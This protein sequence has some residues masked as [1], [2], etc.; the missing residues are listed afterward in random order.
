MKKVAKNAAAGSSGRSARRPKKNTRRTVATGFGKVFLTL[1]LIC[2]ITGSL[3]VGAVA[4]YVIGFVKPYD[5]DLS[6]AKLKFTSIVYATDPS[7]KTPVQID[8]LSGD[9][10]RIWVNLSDVPDNLRNAFI[11]TEDQRFNEHEGVD[12]KRTV[13]AFANMVL[14]FNPSAGGGST[15]TQQLIKNLENNNFNRTIPVKIREIVTALDMEQKYTKNQILEAYLNTINLSNNCYG[16]QTAANLYFGKQ[17]KDLD[18]AQCAVLAGVTENPNAYNPYKH[19]DNVKTRQKYVLSNMYKQK[20]ITK[21]QYDA[22]VAEPLTYNPKTTVVHSWFVDTVINDVAD[23]LCTQKGYTHDYALSQIYTQGYQIYTTEN[24][25]VQSAMDAVYT[26]DKYWNKGPDGNYYNSAMMIVDY[27]GQVAGIEGDRGKKSANMILDRASDPTFKRQPGSSIKPLAD[28]GPAIELGLIN[29]SSGVEDGPVTTMGGKPWPYDGGANNPD[30]DTNPDG[31]YRNIPVVE[32]LA[33]SKNAVAAQILQ[34][35]T[36]LKSYNFLTG[37]LGFTSLVK[38][39]TDKDGKVYSDIGIWLSIG[40][41][42]DGVTVR[43]M[44]GAYEIYGDGGV[45]TKPYTY[46]KVLDSSGNVVLQN[47][48]TAIQAVSPETATIVNKLL[49]QNI[50]RSDGTANRL[51]SL[52]FPCGGKTGTTTQNYDRWFCGVTPDYVG[53]VWTGYDKNKDMTESTNPAMMAWKYVMTKVQ[54]NLPDKSF[55]VAGNLVQA[56]YD[57]WSGTIDPSGDAVGWYK[58]TDPAVTA[59]PDAIVQ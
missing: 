7:T 35:L 27:S 57:S 29:W 46:T 28:Y 38:S 54:A 49:Q 31:S 6:N 22:A 15:I 5:I 42:T 37:K 24:L 1:V 20:M 26:D 48:P 52:T 13:G 39:R 17:V 43:E 40:A 16:V 56:R 59:A 32:A 14:H 25:Q 53:V 33:R 8:E 10:N 18:L 11:A 12:I 50:Q 34:R 19:P 44:A 4:L 2:V 36:P 55:P 51:A 41:L 9:Q 21:Q 45:Y 23:D 58:A 3:V 47:K 30:W